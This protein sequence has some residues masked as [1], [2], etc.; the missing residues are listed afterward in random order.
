MKDGI[1]GGMSNFQNSLVCYL[2]FFFSPANVLFD[3]SL[4][5]KEAEKPCC[6]GHSS[7]GKGLGSAMAELRAGSQHPEPGHGAGSSRAW[8]QHSLFHIQPALVLS[9]LLE[10]EWSGSLAGLGPYLRHRRGLS[11]AR[12]LPSPLWGEGGTGAAGVAEGPRGWQRNP[13]ARGERMGL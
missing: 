2:Y 3:Q 10:W 8:A 12:D 6:P 5:W 1:A 13:C 7:V 9:E 4:L 11:G